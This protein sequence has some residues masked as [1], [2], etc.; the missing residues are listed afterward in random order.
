MT[1]E[2]LRDDMN[3]RIATVDA[4]LLSIYTA[5]VG[6]TKLRV[7]AEAEALTEVLWQSCQGVIPPGDGTASF[8]KFHIFFH[9]SPPPTSY[10]SKVLASI[11]ALENA[12]GYAEAMSLVGPL[13]KKRDRLTDQLAAEHLAHMQAVQDAADAHAA[14]M[15]KAKAAADNDPAVIAAKERLERLEN[16]PPLVRGKIKLPAEATA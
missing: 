7:V 15:D 10:F 16:P 1:T 8:E 9:N 6:L 2:Q 12:D 13:V 11:T 14:A 5:H 3:R 4:R